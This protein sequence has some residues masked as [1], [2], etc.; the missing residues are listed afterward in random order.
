MCTLPI[1]T[2]IASASAVCLGPHGAI[3]QLA[4]QREVSRQ[5]LYRESAGVVAAVEGTAVQSLR[6]QLAELEQQRKALQEQLRQAVVVDADKQAQFVATGQARG[7]SLTSL[8]ALLQIFLGQATPSRATLGRISRKAAQR[9]RAV[10]A[11]IDP[12]SRALVQQV[13]ADEIYVAHRPVLMTVEQ[14]SM[15][16]VGARRVDHCDGGEW[17]KEFEQLPALQQVTRDGGSGLR[18]GV[19]RVNELRRQVGQSAVA[20]QE[21]HFHLLHRAR[22]ALRQVQQKAVRA[23]RAAETA[24]RTFENSNWRGLRGSPMQSR[25]AKQKWQKAEAAFDRWTKQER[26]FEQLRLALRPFTADGE[27]NTRARAEAQVKEALAELT[28]PE[29]TRARRRLLRPETFT[30][31][32]ATEK[33]L[34]SLPLEPELRQAA[35]R[36]EGL[37][38]QGL[39]GGANVQSGARRGVVVMAGVLLWLWGEAGQKAV[40]AV[41]GV[42]QQAWRASSLVEGLNSV[43]RMQQGTQK[44]LTPELL[45]LKRLYWNMHT[46]ESGR[47]KKQSP[48]KLLGLC[49]PTESWWDL[50]KIPPE[51]LRLQ[52]SA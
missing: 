5:T 47:R 25:L 51:Q 3:S 50:I 10:L 30:F 38:K 44:R 29:W 52:M 9:A 32:D 39:V 14:N 12:P 13:A 23:L 35:V 20:D 43:V 31:L 40:Q 28:G 21:D 4:Q 48:Y 15:C 22:H 19:E 8:H 41:R 45:D 26:A 37:K 18:K 34:E 11:Q 16:W 46:F 42:L 49:L 27:W 6:Q 33:R 24:Q 17:A 7:I 36:A 2:R 1:A